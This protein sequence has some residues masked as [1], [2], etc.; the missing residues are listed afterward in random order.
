MNWKPA[1]ATMKPYKPGRSI[2]DAQKEFDLAEIVKLASN[3]NPYGCSPLVQ[4]ILANPDVQIEMYPETSTPPLRTKLA[5][6][7]GV[8]ESNLILGNGS[9]DIITIICRAL[10]NRES[11]TLMPTPSFPQYAHNAKIEGAEVREIPLVDGQ[12]DLDCF[13]QEIDSSTAVIWIC[14]PNNPT[15]D[16]IPSKRLKKFLDAVPSTTLTVLDEAYFEYITEESYDNPIQWLSEYPNLMILRTFSKAYGLA[17]FRVGY[18][19]ASSEVIA[20]LNKVR[21]PFNTGSLALLAAEH[22][23]ADQAFIDECRIANEKQRKRF[24]QF[25]EIHNLH[26]NPSEANFVLIEVPMDA[27]EATDK[28]LQQGFIV[29]S[30]NLLGT[31]NRIRVTIGSEEQNNGFFKAFES[32][33]TN[34]G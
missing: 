26:I 6:K 13:L 32:L 1:L 7:L 5:K 24:K 21:N 30:G 12:H 11:N 31:P 34:R 20:E 28:L 4:K 9:D 16:L 10:L 23:L 3:E 2:D 8:D 33:M 25:A 18:G 17:S 27:D 14:S 29:R 19:V 22:A 15:G